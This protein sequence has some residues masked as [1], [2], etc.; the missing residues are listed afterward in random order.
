MLTSDVLQGTDHEV[1]NHADDQ[2]LDIG[3]G[4]HKEGQPAVHSLHEKAVD[5]LHEHRRKRQ[6]DDQRNHDHHRGG[7][8]V[9]LADFAAGVAE[10]LGHGDG[11]GVLFQYQLGEHVNQQHIEQ[12]R[13]AAHDGEYN[14]HAVVELIGDD[15]QIMFRDDRSDVCVR[16]VLE[17]AVA[18]IAREVVAFLPKAFAEAGV[19]HEDRQSGGIMHDFFDAEGVELAAV[20]FLDGDV[21]SRVDAVFLP[22][23]FGNQHL[24]VRRNF[25]LRDVGEVAAVRRNAVDHD[26]LAGGIVGKLGQAV[27]L[28]LCV[29]GGNGGF[30]NILEIGQLAVH[31]FLAEVVHQRRHHQ[32][33]E[34]QHVGKQDSHKQREVGG[35]ILEDDA[36][37]EA[38]EE[39]QSV[40]QVNDLL[41]VAEGKLTAEEFQRR[42]P[43]LAADD[44]QIHHQK[45]DQRHKGGQPEC[46]RA[47]DR[48]VLGE[49]I[50]V[51]V[52]PGKILLQHRVA[53]NI[54]HDC[55]DE[56]HDDGQGD[57]V[58]QQFPAA[59]A[60]SA[61]RADDRL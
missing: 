60:R 31:H 20:F 38:C 34:Q 17:L 52:K 15:H 24:V 51:Q 50:A 16:N 55:G 14:A 10:N 11:T 3:G 18:E 29:G 58:P 30:E 21:L 41:L 61:K 48:A 44:D 13:K 43:Q 39:A 40:R 54:S 12:R 33:K 6:G 9:E 56:R 27:F 2:H 5:P 4:R 36:Q 32:A 23:A 1:G 8:D 37:A 45:D 57:V 22:V 19:A 49:G 35:D 59:V 46:F 7:G 26:F 25:N 42:E 47:P 53:E 28:R